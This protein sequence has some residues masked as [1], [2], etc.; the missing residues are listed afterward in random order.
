MEFY[1]NDSQDQDKLM[2]RK[3]NPTISST[4]ISERATQNEPT[5]VLSPIKLTIKAKNSLNEQT[6]DNQT[7]FIVVKNKNSS[8]EKKERATK[9]VARKLENN[10]E[11][12]NKYQ[13]LQSIEL[14][15]DL[16]ISGVDELSDTRELLKQVISVPQKIIH[17]HALLDKADLANR[18]FYGRD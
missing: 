14:T 15:E 8:K 16:D 1:P 6:G 18:K 10:I 4:E 2:M 7:D 12:S 5:K 9:K 3:N 11:T 17:A 13:A